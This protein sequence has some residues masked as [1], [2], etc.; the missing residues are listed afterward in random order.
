MINY[1]LKEF[2]KIVLDS[3]KN[4]KAAYFKN[5]IDQDYLP[6]WFDFLNCIY[7]EW[8]HPTDTE[9]ASIVS[10]HNEELN[11]RVIVGKNLYFSALNGAPNINEELKK[12]FPEIVKILEKISKD[13]GI[14]LTTT[15]PK[16]CLGPYQNISHIDPWPGFSLQC[17]GQTIWTL[18]DKSLNE[19]ESIEY[20]ETFEM[21]PGDLV[22]FPQGMYHQIE[23]SAPRASLQFNTEF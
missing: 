20:K 2:K 23:V 18:S 21:N 8:Q 16:I 14:I 13:S 15:G 1:D 6:S 22:F 9:M 7:Q 12:Y 3:N 10:K 11:G 17:Q 19:E 5:F 4:F